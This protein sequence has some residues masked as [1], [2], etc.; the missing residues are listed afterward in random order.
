MIETEEKNRSLWRTPRA[1]WLLAIT[2]VVALGGAAYGLYWY[3]VARFIEYTDDA[4]VS[5]NVV[6]ITPRTSGTVVAIGANN[7][8]FVKAGYPLVRL[9]QAD[10]AVRLQRAEA[11][12]AS[13]VRRVRNLFATNAELRADVQ[14]Y[15]T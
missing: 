9:D 3:R 4:Y 2:V 8:Q 11:N 1:R 5:G 12:L 15:R 6:D 7:T 13:T 14:V 10:A